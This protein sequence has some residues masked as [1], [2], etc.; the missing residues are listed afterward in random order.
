MSS[1]VLPKNPLRFLPGIFRG[2]PA[3]DSKEILLTIPQEW[4]QRF[5]PGFLQKFTP[6]KT[7]VK[8]CIRDYSWDACIVFF[9]RNSFMD[10]FWNLFFRNSLWNSSIVFSGSSLEV[11]SGFSLGFLFFEFQLV[12][13]PGFFN[14]FLD[15]SRHFFWDNSRHSISDGFRDSSRK[16]S[17]DSSFSAR[18]HYE[19]LLVSS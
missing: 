15:I 2:A 9:F 4:F 13:F 16:F 10:F 19:Y 3:D 17:E 12:F 1:R 14:L 7:I 8:D 11:P 6:M 5:F 18:F